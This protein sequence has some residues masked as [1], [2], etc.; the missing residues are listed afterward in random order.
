MSLVLLSHVC[1]HLQ[2]VSKARLSA[3]S[4]PLT[5]LHLA[6]SLQLQSNG[7]IASV[8]RGSPAG[9]DREYTPTT[10]ANVATRRLWLAMKYYDNE[11]VLS[12]MSMVSR[13]KQRVWVGVEELQR[14][15]RGEPAAYVD[16]LRPGECLFVGTDS[17]LFEAREA[18]E[19]GVGGQLLCRVR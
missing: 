6:L 1:S 15:A 3:T 8:T 19:R 14:L 18:I 5:K 12:E 10:Q 9:P 16:G 4:I 2:N 11:P 17:G 13:P 7:F